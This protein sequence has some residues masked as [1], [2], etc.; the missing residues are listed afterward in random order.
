[1]LDV[2]FGGGGPILPHPL[3]SGHIAQNKGTQELRFI[4]DTTSQHA[5]PM[6][7]VRTLP[8]R[9]RLSQS[10]NPFYTFPET[11]S[12]HHDL[13]IVNSGASTSHE[14]FQTATVL[15]VKFLG[16]EAKVCGKV[17]LVHQDA[18]RNLDGVCE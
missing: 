9:N 12:S 16:K 17:M 15:V 4:H 13:E 18:K 6:Q 7:N 2:S 11:E 14:K 5:H 3:I 10:W 1:M 8:Y